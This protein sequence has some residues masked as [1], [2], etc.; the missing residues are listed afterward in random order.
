MVPSNAVLSTGATPSSAV[1]TSAPA[2]V[3]TVASAPAAP[4]VALPIA[5]APTARAAAPPSGSTQEAPVGQVE[6]A[7]S[8]ANDVYM[9]VMNNRDS[10]GVDSAFGAGLANANRGVAAGLAAQHEHYAIRLLGMSFGSVTM[11]GSAT[12]RVSVTK[13]ESAPLYSDSGALIRAGGA[14]TVALVDIVQQI[15]GRW[16]VTQ[17]YH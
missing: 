7:V 3:P 14:Y 17:V 10:S 8:Y 11:L 4:T 16:V 9:Q 15:N 5:P 6:Q 13:T 2:S 1:A 12:A